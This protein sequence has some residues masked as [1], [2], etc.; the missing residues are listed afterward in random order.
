MFDIYGYIGSFFLS[1]K[2]NSF[3]PREKSNAVNANYSTTFKIP[4]LV[5]AAGLEI[6][7]NLPCV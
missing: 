5:W 4:A 1:S 2:R 3:P 7:S 6:K